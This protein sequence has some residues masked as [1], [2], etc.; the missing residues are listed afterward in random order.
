[1]KRLSI[2]LFLVFLMLAL[3]GCPPNPDDEHYE[4]NAYINAVIRE[5]IFFKHSA[6]GLCFACYYSTAS[7]TEV[8][9]EKVE[10]PLINK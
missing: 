5:M 6:S 10:H 1:M 8:P 4:R 9:C 3:S 2:A 7:M